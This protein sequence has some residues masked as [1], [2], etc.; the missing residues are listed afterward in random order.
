MKK[1][2]LSL[3]V[4]PFLLVG[5][6]SKTPSKRDSVLVLN[7]SKITIPEDSTFQ[8]EVVEN[9]L[10]NLVFWYSKD[11]D[12][13]TIDDDGLVTAIKE[14]STIAYAQCGQTVAKCLVVVT[15]YEAKEELS[16]SLPKDSYALNTGDI[17]D[18]PV[19]VKYGKEEVAV[20]FTYT[21]ENEGIV[22]IYNNQVIGMAKGETAV[23]ITASYQSYQATTMVN[24]TVY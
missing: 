14:G 21:Y 7:E 23:I 13:A 3:L 22:S 12:V 10:S 19:T 17:F 24:I 1:H 4:L 6:G 20:S 8:L 5:C 16:I 2:F 18:L 11:E 9:S 15:P